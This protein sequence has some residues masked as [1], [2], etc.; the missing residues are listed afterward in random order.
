MHPDDHPDEQPVAYCGGR[1]VD[2][3]VMEELHYLNGDVL[4]VP[5]G[6]RWLLD[7]EEVEPV[8]AEA[9]RAVCEPGA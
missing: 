7:G 4:R 1:L 3:P 2:E 8:V 9:F 6:R 5:V